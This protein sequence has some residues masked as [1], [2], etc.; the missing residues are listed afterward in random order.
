MRYIVFVLGVLFF[1]RSSG[2]QHL[3]YC[4]WRIILDRSQSLVSEL[5]GKIVT[6]GDDSI[7]FDSK[8]G[9]VR[10]SLDLFSREAAIRSDIEPDP[11]SGEIVRGIRL[12]KPGSYLDNVGLYYDRLYVEY[13]DLQVSY[14]KL[15]ERFKKPEITYEFTRVLRGVGA[16]GNEYQDEVNREITFDIRKDSE[17][18][19]PFINVIDYDAGRSAPAEA[20]SLISEVNQGCQSGQLISLENERAAQE[21]EIED[22]NQSA[23]N[24][25]AEVQQDE[26]ISEEQQAESIREIEERRQRELEQREEELE[27]L[28]RREMAEQR[29][30]R[31]RA[32]R[33]R[34]FTPTFYLGGS[35]ASQSNIGIAR[36]D[37]EDVGQYILSVAGGIDLAYLKASGSYMVENEPLADVSL[38]RNGFPEAGN[39]TADSVKVFTASVVAGLPLMVGKEVVFFVGGGGMYSNFSFT[40]NGEDLVESF[41]QIAPIAQ[42]SLTW[43]LPER[44]GGFTLAYQKSFEGKYNDTDR[45]GFY[46]HYHFKKTR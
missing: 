18:W 16:D 11:A 23:Q 29:R 22:I 44:G 14:M 40:D 33:Q 8:D 13:K 42:A 43:V 26:S 10:T 28:R 1:A 37:G 21:Q 27:Q 20:Q 5:E 25:V 15:G 46:V 6:L 34:L 38:A 30:L 36:N 2:A 24:E 39:L 19:T 35:A 41:T 3:S 17:G 9:V 7:P 31:L 32:R 4:D 45:L 12:D